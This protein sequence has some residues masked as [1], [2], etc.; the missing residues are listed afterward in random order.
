[1]IS[2]T[3]AILYFYRQ[4]I[5]GSILLNF[6]FLLFGNPVVFIVL[7]KLFLGALIF[8][9]YKT[10]YKHQLYFYQNLSLSTVKLFSFAFLLDFIF[11]ILSAEIYS[12]IL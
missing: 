2:K 9:L 7:F 3:R 8:Y 1:M 11:I 4:F 12:L 6:F 10:S 5:L